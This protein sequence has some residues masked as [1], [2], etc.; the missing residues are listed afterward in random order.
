MLRAS[1]DYP[2]GKVKKVFFAAKVAREM[3]RDNG[4][5]RAVVGEDIN[6]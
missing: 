6:K 3:E 5:V 4:R 2:V 1:N